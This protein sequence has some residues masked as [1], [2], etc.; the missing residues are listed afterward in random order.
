MTRVIFYVCIIISSRS[1]DFNK[2]TTFISEKTLVN[3]Q[4]SSS[5]C[6]KFSRSYR[7][8]SY[9]R[10]QDTITVWHANI[11]ACSMDVFVTRICSIRH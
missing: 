3:Q 7:I 10:R 9:R 1:S 5:M 6:V 8:V 2:L 4:K 11:N